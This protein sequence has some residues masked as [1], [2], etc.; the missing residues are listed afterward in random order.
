MFVG[1]GLLFVNCRVLFVVGLVMFVVCWT[2]VEFVVRCL[3]FARGV[4]FVIWCV[5]CVG[6]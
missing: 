1:C 5:S 2:L 3:S 4:C 6:R